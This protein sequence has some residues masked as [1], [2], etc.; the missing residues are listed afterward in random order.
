MVKIEKE[1]KGKEETWEGVKEQRRKER[2][3]R[4]VIRTRD[5]NRKKRVRNVMIE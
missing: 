2:S 1:A 3:G 4:K 5:W